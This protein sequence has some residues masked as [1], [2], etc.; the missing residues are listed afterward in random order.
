MNMWKKRWRRNNMNFDEYLEN[1]LTEE[2]KEKM[3]KLESE[4]VRMMNFQ[5]WR[6]AFEKHEGRQEF[7]ITDYEDYLIL[8]DLKVFKKEISSL[9][10]SI[11]IMD[12]DKL[13]GGYCLKV[14]K[15]EKKE[16]IEEVGGEVSKLGFLRRFLKKLMKPTFF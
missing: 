7:F 1:K 11:E 6:E 13:Y 16:E 12:N 2:D 3:N 5:A 8:E 9:G 10:Y 15:K 14:F 4:L